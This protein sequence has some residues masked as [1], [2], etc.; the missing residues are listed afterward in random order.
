MKPLCLMLMCSDVAERQADGH[1]M[2]K[3]HAERVGSA[4]VHCDSKANGRLNAGAAGAERQAD[5][6]HISDAHAE[7]V[8]SHLSAAM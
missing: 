4:P 5:K 2:S 1:D 6:H 7:Y 3:S 8:N